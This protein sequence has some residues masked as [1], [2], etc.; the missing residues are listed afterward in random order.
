MDG[1]LPGLILFTA[2]SLLYSVPEIASPTY[3]C[4]RFSAERRDR[5]AQVYYLTIL[6][7]FCRFCSLLFLYEYL[8]EEHPKAEKR[9][10]SLYAKTQY[11]HQII[12]YDSA[13][14]KNNLPIEKSAASP[15]KITLSFFIR[16][17][18]IPP[19]LEA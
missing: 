3:F 16:Q 15:A 2:L 8:T 19:R 12:S 17:Y 18:K 6:Y 10:Q 5:Y 9:V 4:A 14:S 1:P 7:H 13:A 11:S